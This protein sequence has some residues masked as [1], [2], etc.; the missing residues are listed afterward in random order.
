MSP[1]PELEAKYPIGSR[2]NI[3]FTPYLIFCSYLVSLIG[4]ATTV[5][6]LHRRVSGSGW[7]AW[8]QIAGCSVSFGLVAIW[9]MHFV[10]NRAIVLGDGEDEIQLYYSPTYTALSAV[11]PVVVIFL[12]LTIADRFYRRSKH[13]AIRVVSLVV[14]GFCAGAAIT[15]MH[16]LGNNG[17]EN[18]RLHLNWPHVFGAAGIAV[19]ASLLSFGLF[20]HW[21]GSWLNN[22]FRR[23]VVACFLALA[24]SGMHWTGAAGTWYEVRGYHEGSRQERNIT[25]TIALCLCLSACFVC[26]LLGFLKQRHR[27]LLKDRAQQVV[28]ACATFDESG[29]LLVSQGGL[30]PCQTITRQFHQRTFADEFNTAHPVFQWIF[31]VSRHWG[32]V[33]DLIPSMREHLHNTGYL[34]TTSPSTAPDSR[35]SFSSEGDSTYSATF[36]E[37]FCVTAYDIAK[38]LD[39]G[40]Q[41]LG[42]LY[43][44]VV[45]TG[46]SMSMARA[47]FK[48]PNDRRE[49]LA[50]D[51]ANRYLETGMAS[52]IL[53]GRGQML[54]LTKKADAN[55]VKRLQNLGYH[56]AN[57]EQ[58]GDNLARSLQVTRD[59]LYDMVDRWHTFTDREPSIPLSGT[60]L[61]CFL[62]QPAPGMRGLDI[63]VPR[64]NPDRLPMVKLANGDLSLGELKVLVSFN[65]LSL[66]GCLAKSGQILGLGTKKDDAFLEN[67]RNRILDLL[68]KAPE[69]ALHRAIFSA[70]QLDIVH[71]VVGK[72]ERSPA[73]V[74]AF[75]GIKEIYI[76][77]LHSTTLKC[78]PMSFFQ[79]CLRSYPGSPDHQILAIRNHK[80]FATLVQTPSLTEKPEKRSNKWIFRLRP[81]RSMSSEM[82]LQPDSC[83]EKGLVNPSSPCVDASSIHPWGS[84]MVTSTQKIVHDESKKEGSTMELSDMGVKSEAGVAD[85]EQQTLADRLISITTAFRDP[86][87]T[88]ALPKDLFYGR[89]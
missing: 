37:L 22:I 2:P 14:C 19:G 18:Y 47:V 38:T 88:R 80:E 73:T 33:S 17:T 64:A 51:V 69:P 13:A 44:E 5:E 15:E 40:L 78:I 24:V 30:L 31:R 76:Q 70:K 10:G 25:L 34:Q 67:F 82:T 68:N 50:T 56:F 62:L 71:G 12:G 36:R 23:C 20:F 9:C 28:L 8:V 21:S 60:Y 79:T 83:S 1:S 11:I 29:K 59:D 86:H 46:T 89:T 58:V 55:E 75:C 65:G 81:Y 85:T 45:T 61:A 26:F 4:S 3:S 7:R 66:D 57:I 43:E 42:N 39:T 87:A 77:S 41:N 54:V 84:I 16:Y 49:I 63:V 6:L 53:F 74:F 48:D 72:K 27:R 52:P 32:G 35:S